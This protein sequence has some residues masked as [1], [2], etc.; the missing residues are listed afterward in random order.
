MLV[1]CCSSFWC[2]M[3]CAQPLSTRF[4]GNNTNRA[5][6][7]A[8]KLH[9]LGTNFAPKSVRQLYNCPQKPVHDVSMS[10]HVFGCA[11]HA[12][13]RLKLSNWTLPDAGGGDPNGTQRR[14]APLTLRAY[15]WAGGAETPWAGNRNFEW[16]AAASGLKSPYSLQ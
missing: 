10:V 7:H 16:R 1:Y 8:S 4:L 6:T 9:L 12:P 3:F 15:F 5:P 2:T 14:R 11:N 13:T